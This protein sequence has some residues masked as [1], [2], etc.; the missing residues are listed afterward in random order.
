[1]GKELAVEKHKEPGSPPSR[2]P[3][4]SQ[5]SNNRYNNSACPE[6]DVGGV[7]RAVAVKFLTH[8]YKVVTSEALGQQYTSLR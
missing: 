6:V 5:I 1:M 8:A 4:E 2:Y 3:P 7:K